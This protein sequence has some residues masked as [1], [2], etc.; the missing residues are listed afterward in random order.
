MDD[1]TNTGIANNTLQ[2]PLFGGILSRPYIGPSP[3]ANGKELFNAIGNDA[4]NNR[5][6]ILQDNVN[7]GI[8]NRFTELSISA[9]A[10]VNYKITDYLSIGNRTG[11][12][13][14][15]YQRTFARSPLGYL[16]IS[17]A[18]S[19]GSTYG[20]NEDFTTTNDLTFNSITNITFN[21][22]L[23]TTRLVQVHTWT[24]SKLT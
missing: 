11:I 19:D 22:L 9:N 12:E 16:S 24:I 20:G 14:K 5:Q 4:T 23:E 6:W 10:N 7:G 8:Q 2:N 1:E 18:N 21:K 15:E 17:V 13:Y 3:Y